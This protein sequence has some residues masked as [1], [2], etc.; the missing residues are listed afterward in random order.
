M[1]SFLE[2]LVAC[3]LLPVFSRYPMRTALHIDVFFHVS[4][5]EGELHIL[6]VCCLDYSDG[7]FKWALYKIVTSLLL[8]Y[9]V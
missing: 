5:G 7:I 6:L 8:N 2:I 4:G 9:T 1:M 3:D